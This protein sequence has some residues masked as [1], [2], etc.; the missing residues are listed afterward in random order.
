MQ[1]YSTKLFGKKFMIPYLIAV[2]STFKEKL[3]S[4]PSIVKLKY[5]RLYDGFMVTYAS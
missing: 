3:N 5:E 4:F 2:P 1:K